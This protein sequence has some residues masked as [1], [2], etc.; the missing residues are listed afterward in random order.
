MLLVGL[1][2]AVDVLLVSANVLKVATGGWFALAIAFGVGGI[3]AARR[4][5]EKSAAKS[6]PQEAEASP[7]RDIEHL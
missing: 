5:I 2:L 4:T 7:E 6:S 1:F 3:D